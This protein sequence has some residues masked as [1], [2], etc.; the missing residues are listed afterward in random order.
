ML[1]AVR[2]SRAVGDSTLHYLVK[3]GEPSSE[4]GSIVDIIE[5]SKMVDGIGGIVWEGSLVL[6][7]LLKQC[8]TSQISLVE[9]GGGAGVCSIVGALLG[10]NALVT[11][12]EIDLA[13][14]NIQN[15]QKEHASLDNSDINALEFDWAEEPSPA[16]LQHLVDNDR[17]RV[18]V[19]VEVACLL[20]QQTYLVDSLC[21][22]CDLGTIILISFDAGSSKYESSFYDKM[23]KRGFLSKRIFSGSVMFEDYSPLAAKEKLLEGLPPPAP[24]MARTYGIVDCGSS[25]IT[26][27]GSEACV[28]HNI[29][30]FYRQSAVRTCRNCS[31]QFFPA[32]NKDSSCRTHKG[33]YVCRKHPAE[34]R[35]SIDGHGDGLGYYGTGEEGKLVFTVHTSLFSIC[36]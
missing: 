30:V 19:G 23:E 7:E 8:D 25:P 34:T 15:C 35:L 13:T 4:G 6:C 22:I 24:G 28:H 5:S 29:V 12:Q 1:T 3:D 33:Y 11:D 10:M 31:K 17:N 16:L 32:L 27:L 9:L 14:V 26:D 18:I 21:R 36:E 20:K 2:D